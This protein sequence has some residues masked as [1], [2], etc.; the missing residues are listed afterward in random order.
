MK[1]WEWPSDVELSVMTE[2]EIDE[3]PDA[4]REAYA[5]AFLAMAKVA[6]IIERG[7]AFLENGQRRQ[8]RAACWQLNVEGP[9]AVRLLRAAQERTRERE[10]RESA[11]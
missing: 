9:R 6:A 2:A 8:Y 5:A 11:S 3:L 10:A 4:E 1:V 7:N